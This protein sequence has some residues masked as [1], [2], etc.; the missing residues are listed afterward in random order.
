MH[1]HSIIEL[2]EK[3][4][5]REI[6]PVEVT[7]NMLARI[8][9]LDGS[10]HAYLNVTAER[11]VAQAKQ[12]EKEILA[13]QWRGPLHGIPIGLKDIIFTDFAKTTAGTIIHKDFL[14]SFSATVVR[15]L[16]DH[17]AV[18]LGKLT[19]TEQAFSDHH[20]RVQVPTNPWGPGYY[21]GSSSSGSG[22]ASAIG[23]AYG[24][25]GSDTGGSIRLPSA[26][27]GITGLKPSWGRVSRH[28]VFPLADSLDHIGPM[29][30]SA[31][32]AALMLQV[33]A[34]RDS[35][36]ATSL[37]APVPDYSTQAAE[38]IAGLRI[39]MPWDYATGGVDPEVEQAWQGV[40]EALASLGAIIKPIEFPRW[41]DAV[42]LWPMLCAAETAWAHRDHHPIRK[43]QYGSALSDFIDRGQRYSGVELAG[44]NVVRLEFNGNLDMLF[45]EVDVFIVPVMP[46]KLPTQQEW[47]AMAGQDFSYYLRFTIPAD[48]AGI[49]TITFPAGVDSNGLPIGMQLCGQRLDEGV[50]C[51]AAAAFQ[52]VTDWHLRRPVLHGR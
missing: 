28:G 26:A 51:R 49:P 47:Q 17:G 22:V 29:A 10:Y 21:C 15:R 38:S 6:S 9:Q 19:T 36:D 43:D 5:K 35:N 14:P 50:V 20:P 42:G 1:F 30:R 52:G 7:T 45:D 33:I 27:N 2:S 11:A 34:G 46:T 12:A 39:G 37:R 48:L 4:K 16:E 31:L 3:L 41:Q 25:L 44:A 13:G 23:L 18:T 40:A 32:D 24:T 8:E